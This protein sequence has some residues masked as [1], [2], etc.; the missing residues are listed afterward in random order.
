MYHVLESRRI[1]INSHW[2]VLE[3]TRPIGIVHVREGSQQSNQLV[4]SGID[5]RH[6]N[7]TSSDVFCKHNLTVSLYLPQRL[8]SNPPSSG[9]GAVSIIAGPIEF[10]RGGP[11]TKS[12][13]LLPQP[14]VKINRVNDLIVYVQT[15]GGSILDPVR[16]TIEVSHPSFVRFMSGRWCWPIRGRGSTLVAC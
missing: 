13:C 11:L 3:T 14:P 5:Q 6:N 15:V 2:E 12:L 1:G 10:S 7:K 9:L 16:S 4:T 8:H